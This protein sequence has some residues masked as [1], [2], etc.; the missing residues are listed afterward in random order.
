M[1]TVR[2]T[3]RKVL[4]FSATIFSILSLWLLTLNLEKVFFPY[5]HHNSL[6][7]RNFRFNSLL[8]IDGPVVMDTS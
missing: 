6:L 2:E 5:I 8:D 1:F 4:K 3:M 7:A